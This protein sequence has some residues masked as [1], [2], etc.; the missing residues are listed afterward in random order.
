MSPDDIRRRADILKS[1]AG[2]SGDDPLIYIQFSIYDLI[3]ERVLHRAVQ[4]YLGLL[5]HI[6]EDVRQVGV[7]L[8]DGVDVGWMEGH[9]DH[10]PD[11]A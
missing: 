9:S 1:A 6:V 10:R 7:H 4:A 11:L 8:V 3:L 5:L 2:T